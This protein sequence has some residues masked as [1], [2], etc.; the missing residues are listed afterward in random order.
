MN[1]VDMSIFVG[2]AG[3]NLFAFIGNILFSFVTF[4]S[5]FF[6]FHH[7]QHILGDGLKGLGDPMDFNHSKLS[8]K[9]SLRPVSPL[10]T[11]SIL[12]RSIS[13]SRRFSTF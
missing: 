12:I 13:S 2:N 6:L 3:N 8:Y 11:M 7:A 4:T 9:R 1:G 5:L 10:P